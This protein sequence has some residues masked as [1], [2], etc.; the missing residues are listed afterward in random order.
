MLPGAQGREPADHRRVTT[1]ARRPS[2]WWLTAPLLLAA[3]AYARVLRGPFV[4]D[5]L[6][7]VVRPG[8]PRP[9]GA[10]AAEAWG[11]LWRG[12]R[13]L[14][15][16]TFAANRALGGLDPLGYHLVN[17]G[18]HLVTAILVYLLAR[19]V[20]SLAGAARW[21]WQ[22]LAVAG[23]WAVHPLG[24]QAVSYVSQRA[25]VLA[26]G[27]MA[28]SLLLLLRA[29]RR[30]A[31][32]GALAWLGAGLVA[33]ALA[34]GSKAMAVTVPA[35]WA[36][37]AFAAPGPEARTSLA[38]PRVRL[39]LLAAPLALAV[40]HGALTLRALTP[41]TGAG[42]RL[43][44]L[45]PWS[46]LLTQLRVVPIYLRLVL[47]P[48]GQSVDW[49]VEPAV[50]ATEPGV[51]A[52]GALLLLLAASAAWLVLAGRR[53]EG[54]DGAAAR[55]AGL[56]LAWFLVV[57]APTS[58]VVPLADPLMEHRAYLASWGV[59]LALVA[60]GER[61]AARWRWPHAGRAGVALLV[62]AGLALA[63]A[64]HARNAVWESALAL[65]SDAT[66]G[67][68]GPSGAWLGLG[69]ALAAGGDHAGALA[70]FRTAHERAR[71]RAPDEAQALHHAGQ[72]LLA[73]GR[74]GEALAALRGASERAPG[75]S[76]MSYSL[77]IAL[78]RTGDL[79]GAEAAARLS[80]AAQGDRADASHLLGA[81]LLEAGGA[82]EAV[83]HL[84]RAAAAAPWI[85]AIRLDLGRAYR[86]VGRSAEACAAW[87]AA[88]G[89]RLAA[90]QGQWVRE[91][92]AAAGCPPG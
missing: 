15:D 13:P 30:E 24:S 36:L 25:E 39:A 92:L 46:Y 86:A 21:R 47:W 33:F 38:A 91:Q 57:L 73:L 88:L 84:E 8:P 83:P 23:L 65:W 66:A 60:A 27:F 19:A 2:P 51:L 90:T 89:L 75:W 61:L 80:L 76:T 3:A 49:D 54:A 14:A 50:S 1:E 42:F 28:A 64:L 5:D 62:S 22:A 41:E 82:A 55:V 79:A 35:L 4:F 78:W 20:L 45:G 44:G 16:L 67:G 52:G 11:A 7:S 10:L 63:G 69:A 12:G 85:P 17:V 40:A 32:R 43:P 59:L 68:R 31:G 34:L 71:G 72:S 9:P 6:T 74:T 87:R 70:A 53:R 48:A 29:G 37:V 77:A 56:G 81:I 18:L 58:S 26:S